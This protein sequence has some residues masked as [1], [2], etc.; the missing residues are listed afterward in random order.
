MPEMKTQNIRPMLLFLIILAAGTILWPEAV[1][2][3]EGGNKW[4]VWL[5]IGRFFNLALVAA[6]LI[7]V[8]RKPLASFF[9]S[10]T[11]SI[12]NQLAEAQEARRQAEAKL[13]E[14]ESRMSRVD[15]ELEEIKLAAEKEGAEEYLRLVESAG[16]DASKIVERARQEIE[17]M[18]RAAQ[19]ELK[20][21][22]A[23]LSVQLAEEKIRNEIT[24]ADRGRLF[25]RF[26][27]RLGENK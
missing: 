8:A 19:L 16:Q 6:I 11:E 22:V 17:G 2:A 18:T 3:S 27:T 21:H 20:K 10:R 1:F 24:D 13:A 14:I 25:A 9:S 26:V 4:G 7:K 23:E 5:D 15:A 12:H